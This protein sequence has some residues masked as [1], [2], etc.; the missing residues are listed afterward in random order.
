[1]YTTLS[2]IFDYYQFRCPPYLFLV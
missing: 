2:S 1:M